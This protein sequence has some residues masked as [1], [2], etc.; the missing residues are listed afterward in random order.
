[1]TVLHPLFGFQFSIKIYFIPLVGERGRYFQQ[2]Q[3]PLVGKNGLNLE[4]YAY[5]SFH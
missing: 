1:M 4:T 2:E 3:I 5:S